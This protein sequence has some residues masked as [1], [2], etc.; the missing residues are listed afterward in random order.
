MIQT[1][2]FTYKPRAVNS[3]QYFSSYN[4]AY[5]YIL[6]SVFGALRRGVFLKIKYILK[7]EMEGQKVVYGYALKNMYVTGLTSARN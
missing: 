5:E 1:L 7:N 2:L 4:T 6:H 3:G